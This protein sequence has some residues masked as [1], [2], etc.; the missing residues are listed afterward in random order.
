MIKHL[1]PKT[2]EEIANAEKNEIVGLALTKLPEYPSGCNYYI[3][4]VNSSA[5]ENLNVYYKLTFT[6]YG[7]PHR[8]ELAGYEIQQHDLM[9]RQW[10]DSKSTA[11][12]DI[13]KRPY[14]DD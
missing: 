4:Y 7:I 10:Y 13:P 14:D 8:W 6:R 3:V 12:V 9:Y 11:E 1:S 5:Y 2:K